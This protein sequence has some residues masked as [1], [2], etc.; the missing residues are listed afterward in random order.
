MKSK[1]QILQTFMFLIEN[2]SFSECNYL[3]TKFDYKEIIA[4]LRIILI[5]KCKFH[6]QGG[7]LDF[8][9]PKTIS[10]LLKCHFVLIIL[11]QR[12]MEL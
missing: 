10:F 4:Q 2:Y 8:F 12:N 5:V 1:I 6:S 7:F 9:L 11:R 3:K